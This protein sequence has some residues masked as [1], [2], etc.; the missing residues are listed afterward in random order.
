MHPVSPSPAVCAACAVILQSV[1][2]TWPDERPMPISSASARRGAT[3]ARQAIKAHALARRRQGNSRDGYREHKGAD[4]ALPNAGGV[5]T[6]R[7]HHVVVERTRSEIP[8]VPHPN[9]G[10]ANQPP[11]GRGSHRPQYSC[12]SVRRYRSA[13]ARRRAIARAVATDRRQARP[14]PKLDDLRRQPFLWGARM[15]QVSAVY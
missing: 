7:R 15:R 6:R 4:P 2:A 9:F 12:P 5:N 10:P 13:L 11:T 14:H 3:Q 1:A 8:L